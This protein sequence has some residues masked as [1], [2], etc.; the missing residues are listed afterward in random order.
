MTFRSRIYFV[1]T[2][3]YDWHIPVLTSLADKVRDWAYNKEL[4]Y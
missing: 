3:V 4:Y 1:A 2:R